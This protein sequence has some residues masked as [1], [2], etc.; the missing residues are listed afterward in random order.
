MEISHVNNLKDSIFL[1]K[2]VSICAKHFSINKKN[3]LNAI[4]FLNLDVFFY[5]H[6]V[7]FTVFIDI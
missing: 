2:Y 7:F 4:F 6:T 3:Q 1:C 5:W